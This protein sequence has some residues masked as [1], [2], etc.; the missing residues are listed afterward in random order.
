VRWLDE[1]PTDYSDIPDLT[2]TEI[3]PDLPPY[4]AKELERIEEAL[5]LM[6]EA[7]TTRATGQ[8]RRRG[9]EAEVEILPPGVDDDR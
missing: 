2:M 8:R 5:K 9:K 1:A 4:S 6:A 3:S 7:R